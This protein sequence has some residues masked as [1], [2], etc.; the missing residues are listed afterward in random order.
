MTRFPP[1]LSVREAVEALKLLMIA[2]AQGEAIDDREYRL[3]RQRAFSDAEVARRLPTFVRL[4]S[5]PKLFWA[6]IREQSPSYQGRRDYLRMAFEPVLSYLTTGSSRPSRTGDSRDASISTAAPKAPNLVVFLCHASPDKAAVRELY[7]RL[8]S[9]GAR[10]WLDENDLLPG[11]D[12][13]LEIRNA[14][15]RSDVVLVCLSAQSVTRAG[16]AQR[17]IRFALDV[18]DE[19]PEGTIFV[20]PVLLE[21][22]RVPDRLSQLHWVRLYDADGYTKLLRALHA[23]ANSG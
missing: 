13:Q 10:P 22:C 11:Q 1:N 8:L 16:F 7:T 5:D 9:D 2:R 6:H 20:I 3:V 12:W 23:R 18:A 15:R 17:E 21:E 19:Q 14:I 4:C